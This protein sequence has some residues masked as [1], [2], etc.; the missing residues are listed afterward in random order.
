[1]ER[2]DFPACPHEAK[3]KGV[4]DPEVA[5]KYVTARKMT[6]RAGMFQR[7]VQV[8]VAHDWMLFVSYSSPRK[9]FQDGA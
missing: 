3:F 5:D 4:I 1:M 8:C 9:R 6:V 7:H 2:C